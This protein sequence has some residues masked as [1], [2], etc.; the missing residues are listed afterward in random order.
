MSTFTFSGDTEDVEEKYKELEFTSQSESE[1][2]FS[3]PSVIGIVEEN[4]PEG[5]EGGSAILGCMDEVV[6]SFLDAISLL[7]E[8]GTCE[9]PGAHILSED[10]SP[11][12]KDKSHDSPPI[13][14]STMSIG[15]ICANESR[16]A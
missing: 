16:H 8:R 13:I 2:G 14:V 4:H 5:N 10:L 1:K 15:E 12:K 3:E 6:G 7:K 11:P 9:R